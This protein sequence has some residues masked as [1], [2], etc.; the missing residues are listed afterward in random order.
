MNSLGCNTPTILREDSTEV[1]SGHLVSVTERDEDE[2]NGIC[3]KCGARV[4]RY[5]DVT[6]TIIN[7]EIVH[8]DNGK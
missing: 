4:V 6:L 7:S 5:G 3:R 2:S 1:V 8:R